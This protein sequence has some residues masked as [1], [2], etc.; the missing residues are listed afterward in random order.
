VAAAAISLESEDGDV[1]DAIVFGE[2]EPKKWIAGSS[3]FER[4]RDLE[5]PE[6]TSLP[7]AR[8]HLAVVYGADNS[9]AVFRN[10]EPY[11]TPYTP[12]SPLQ[13]FTAA[14]ARV[15]LGKRHTGG[16]KP[17]LTGEIKQAA[18]YDR[19][20][21]A[22][23][24]AASFRAAEFAIPESEILAN[25]GAARRTERERALSRIKKSH[26]ALDGIKPLPVSYAGTRVQPAPT[27]NLRRGD[28]KS[29]RRLS[30]R[31]G[32]P[33]LRKLILSSG[34]PRTRRKRSGA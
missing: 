24:V 2:R 27:H 32:C 26:Q 20:L 25:V 4:T 1:F 10:G 30:L 11:G 18:L 8:I 23:E 14:S 6:E 17:F 21:S 12:G 13:T 15:L 7:G 33:R 19:A 16:S 31:E 9:I 29:P 3:G 5:A 22:E 28:V 34:W